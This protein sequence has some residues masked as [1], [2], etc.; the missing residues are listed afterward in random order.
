MKIIWLGHASFRLEMGSEVLLIDPWLSGNPM[1]PDQ[2]MD[3]ALKGVSHILITHGHF[4][5]ASEL[6]Q[7]GQTTGATLCGIPEVCGPFADGGLPT[8]EFNKG[9]T[10]KLGDIA[11]SMVAASHS[12]SMKSNGLDVYAGTE[13]GFMITGEGRTM[14]VSGDTDIMADMDWMG[15][16]YKPEIGILCAGGHYT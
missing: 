10:I 6:Q 11:V 8:I 5:H 13:A 12:S 2:M 3:V 4:D 15:D 16:F 7:I 14:Y 1:F 9:G